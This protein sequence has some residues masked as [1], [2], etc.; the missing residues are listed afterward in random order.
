MHATSR[1]FQRPRIERIT[2]RFPARLDED[3]FLLLVLAFNNG[4][5]D[6]DVDIKTTADAFKPGKDICVGVTGKL[7]GSLPYL[8]KVWLAALGHWWH[9][10]SPCSIPRL[11][12]TP[13]PDVPL[14]LDQR[15]RSY[16]LCPEDIL[17]C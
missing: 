4:R 5:D 12:T 17:G 13:L 2:L 6:G 1:N 10:L 15:E 9:G 7:V 11:R 14:S 16:A 3:F 8:V